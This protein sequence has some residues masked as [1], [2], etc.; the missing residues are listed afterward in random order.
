ML[1]FFRASL[2]NVIGTERGVGGDDD[3]DRAIHTRKFFDDDGVFDVAQARAAV[4]FGK[5]GAHVT[6][7]PELL[8]RLRAGRFGFHPIRMTCGAISAAANSRTSLRS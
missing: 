4:L 6:E 7:L 3:A 1:L 8:D 5:D 2:E